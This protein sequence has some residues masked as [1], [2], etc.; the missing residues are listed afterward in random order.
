VPTYLAKSVLF[1]GP[2]GAVLRSF[3]AT[4]VEAGGSDMAAYRVAKAA[5][6]A[7]GVVTLMPEGT[8]SQDGRLSRARPGASLLAT[9]TGA[10]VL[11]VGVSGTDE[12]LG[13]GRSLPRIG[14]RVTLRVGAPFTLT[15]GGDD[16]RAALAAADE[17]VMRRIAALVDPRHRGDWEP[18]P[19]A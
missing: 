12:L 11:P 8:R 9:R 13:R 3:G 4:P 10:L 5:L 6:D 17:Q 1:K 15:L 19:K 7:G 18:W 16:R 14:A 2:A